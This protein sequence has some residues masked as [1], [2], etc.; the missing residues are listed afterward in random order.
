MYRIDPDDGEM[1]TDR[2]RGSGHAGGSSCPTIVQVST[3]PLVYALILPSSIRCLP[4]SL[5]EPWFWVWPWAEL[6]GERHGEESD[7]DPLSPCTFVL[8][9]QVL[10]TPL[11]LCQGGQMRGPHLPGE[12]TVIPLCGRWK[13]CPKIS[14]A[15]PQNLGTFLY[16]A[17]NWD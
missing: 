3:L 15:N 1:Q 7:I 6:F 12:L 8:T 9:R 16:M 4:P 11:C 17:K 13:H 5:S 14:G 2:M 10:T